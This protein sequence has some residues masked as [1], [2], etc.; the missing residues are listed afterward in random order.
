MIYTVK[1]TSDTTWTVDSENGDLHYIIFNVFKRRFV[2]DCQYNN[3]TECDCKHIV[4][5]KFNIV[6][7]QEEFNTDET[8]LC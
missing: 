3:I 5:S 7:G 2:C 8:K 1:R 4:A 6:T